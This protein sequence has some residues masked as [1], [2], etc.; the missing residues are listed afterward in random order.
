[1][2]PLNIV[3]VRVVA[4]EE[5]EEVFLESYHGL[6]VVATLPGR[7]SDSSYQK[8]VVLSNNAEE[9]REKLTTSGSAL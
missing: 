8:Q 2:S 1:M 4:Y 6:H 3:A 5:G 9:Q 7:N